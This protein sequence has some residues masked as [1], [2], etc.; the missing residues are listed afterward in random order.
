MQS[1]NITSHNML[2]LDN[3]TSTRTSTRLAKSRGAPESAEAQNTHK[4]KEATFLFIRSVVFITCAFF[5][6]CFCYY[7]YYILCIT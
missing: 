4:P 7:I 2:T 1:S 6:D 5:S 3:T